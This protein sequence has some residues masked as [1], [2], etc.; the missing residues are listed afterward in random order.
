MNGISQEVNKRTDNTNKRIL[1]RGCDPRMSLIASKD[2]PPRVG[3]P[4]YVPT[5]DDADFIE[6][7]KTEKWSVIFFAPGACR[8]SAAKM[9][10][11]GGNTDTRGWTLEQYRQLVYKYQGDK[12]QIVESIEEYK[13]IA[14]LGKA[15]EKAPASK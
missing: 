2:I 5:T 15:L 11:P 13:T 12:V 9:P 7:L 4:E 3:N 14:L 10:I 6:K 8:Y 1:A